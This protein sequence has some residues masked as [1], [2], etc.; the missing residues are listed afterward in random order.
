VP[1]HTVALFQTNLPNVAP[2]QTNLPTVAPLQANLPNV[3]ALRRGLATGLQAPTLAFTTNDS[4]TI[5]NPTNSKTKSCLLQR[6]FDFPSVVTT[7]MGSVMGW[8]AS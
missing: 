2:F 7:A 5:N 8:V 3:S 4:C 1:Y 6:L